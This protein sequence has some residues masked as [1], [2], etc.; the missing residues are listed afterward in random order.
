M[1]LSPDGL[2]ATFTYTAS[3][4]TTTGPQTMAMAMGAVSE[5]DSPTTGNEAFSASFE[6]AYSVDQMKRAYG[7]DQIIDGGTLQDGTGITIAV[8][9]PY[10]NPNFV[11]WND[12]GFLSSDLHQ[13][14]LE[15]GLPEPA[16][17][18]TKVDQNGGTNYPS[19]PPSE[20]AGWE[21]ET[22]L[23][24]EWVH[25]IAPGAKIILVEADSTD[26]S[27]YLGAAAVWARD[28][29][30][31]QVVSMSYCD[32]EFAGETQ[33]DSVFQSPAGHGVTW[34]TATGDWTS[35]SYGTQWY[36]AYSPN[37]LAV[38]GTSLYLSDAA[39]DYSSETGWD[40]VAD[41]YCS[42][43]GISQYESQPSYQQGLVIHSG[44]QVINQNG[45]RAV[46][47]VSIDADPSTGPGYYDSFANPEDPWSAV[48]G[49]SLSCPMWA[50]LIAIADKMRI[51]HGLGT[52]DGASQTLPKLYGIYNNP[53]QYAA[54]FHD[55]TSGSNDAY[56]A[57]VGYDLVTGIGSPQANTL[58]PDLAG[59]VVTPTVTSISPPLGP[60]QGGTTVTITGAASP[61]PRRWTSAA[62]RP[63]PSPSFPTPRSRPPARP[64]RAPSTS[65]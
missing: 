6:Y 45:Y 43:G 1:T 7:I 28:Y 37:V 47:D 17:F 48:G 44:N 41:G 50:G 61:A 9:D 52:L 51:N 36:P 14:D 21:D 11:S 63:R 33:Y 38:G 25:A 39:G 35:S 27:D 59:V 10:D 18:F 29:S 62:R 5:S 12:P 19:Q 23:D 32:W 42:D 46:P 4:I 53:A 31:A 40:D 54:D 34:V 26:K 56:S 15:Y 55:I 24:V 2:T 20:D 22:A 8:L 58:I 57:A 49:T 16:G 3:P 65:R 13:F 30:G 60:E 64:A